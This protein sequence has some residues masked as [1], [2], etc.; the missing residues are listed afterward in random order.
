MKLRFDLDKKVAS[1]GMAEVF[2]GHTHGEAGFI[3][4]VVIKRLRPELT[5]SRLHRELRDL[6]ELD[7]NGRVSGRQ[8]QRL[9]LFADQRRF[10][11]MQDGR[12]IDHHRI[13]FPCRL[14]QHR[15]DLGGRRRGVGA[16]GRRALAGGV[17]GD[18]PVDARPGGRR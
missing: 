14:F 17:L 2:I 16:E 1:G 3:K 15:A 12:R 6:G 4:P 13:K 11:S 9:G 10:Q 5:A 8:E 7:G 18:L